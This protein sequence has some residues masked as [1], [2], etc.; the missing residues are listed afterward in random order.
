V[1]AASADG[2]SK[3][4]KRQWGGIGSFHYGNRNDKE[5]VI[6]MEDCGRDLGM[7]TTE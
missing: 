4:K 2:R 5:G 6:G 1:T 7:E 3:L